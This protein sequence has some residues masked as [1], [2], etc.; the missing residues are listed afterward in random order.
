MSN[1]ICS[2]CGGVNTGPA[3]AAPSRAAR[4]SLCVGCAVEAAEITSEQE[5]ASLSSLPEL[6]RVVAPWRRRSRAFVHSR[7]A[8]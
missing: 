2:G 6:D 8:F 1:E 7:G 3:V 4:H 5:R